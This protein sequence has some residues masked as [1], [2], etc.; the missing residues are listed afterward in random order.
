M[1]V[2]KI[3]NVAII[4]ICFMFDLC[5]LTEHVTLNL[6]SNKLLLKYSGISTQESEISNQ[7]SGISMWNFRSGKFK[8]LGFSTPQSVAK[9][10]DI[11]EPRFS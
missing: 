3:N 9:N 7:G 11:P 1:E 4:F 6:S 10:L 5:Y 2:V 8:P